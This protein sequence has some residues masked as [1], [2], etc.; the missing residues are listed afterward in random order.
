MNAFEKRLLVFARRLHEIDDF[1]GM[2]AAMAD[3]IRE[4]VGY[5][6][7]WLAVFDTE[8]RMVRVLAVQGD[9]EEDVWKHT[10]CFPIDDD[11]Y[12]VRLYNASEPQIVE[13]AQIDPNVN[14]AVVE[15]LGN[16]TIIN[17]P[18]RLVDQPFGI[19]GTGSFGDE[20]VRLPTEE[21]LAHLVGIANQLVTA[22]A[23]LVLGAERA[24]AAQERERVREHL[25]NQQRLDSLGELAGGVA[26]DFNNL[27]TVVI[28][29]TSLLH[30]TESDPLRRAEMQT[31]LDASAR[32][33]ELARRMLALG[34][35]QTLQFVRASMSDLVDTTVAMLRRVIPSHV[36]IEVETEPNL[37][38][39]SMDAGQIE[40]V[41]LNLSLNAR[42]AMPDGGT[43]SI[44]TSSVT[45][46]QE[47]LAPYSWAQ[48]GRYARVTVRDTG[49][50]MSAEVQARVFEPFYTTKAESK[51]TGLGLAVCRGII[52]QHEG[53][54]ACESTPG[55]GTKFSV[56]LPMRKRK[57]PTT[58]FEAAEAVQ[59]GSERILVADDEDQVCLV[60]RRILE[61]A[62]YSVLT[63]E[64]GSQ[65]IDAL[66]REEF[67]LVILDAVMPHVG[68]RK[69]FEAIRKKKP[70]QK[71]LFSSG[72]GAEELSARF[73][74]DVD[75]PLLPKPFAPEQLL[76][77]VREVLDDDGQ[78]SSEAT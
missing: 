42:D 32:G 23:R 30:A 34:K 25:A 58:Q 78:K 70:Q 12:M 51:G 76:L 56:Y 6:N 18:M 10:P 27:L 22:G 52:E 73:L 28:A 7:A 17:V 13:D 1:G 44:A 77:R 53:F 69:A 2:I 66:G 11:P 5:N 29:T 63:V 71:I 57:Q 54:I 21:E 47:E 26:H 64:D 45:L 20:G 9:T 49:C 19:L 3:E 72:Y 55:E 75:A 65:A 40:Q 59:G 14:R 41:L 50:G 61:N 68:G 8:E 74:S 4:T 39:L 35:R 38:A 24:A 16:R 46:T 37:S 33:A 31:I 36:L 15:Q 43:L 67:D 62:G 48:P 60:V